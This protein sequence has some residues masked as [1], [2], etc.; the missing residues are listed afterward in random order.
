[1][2]LLC[3]SILIFA[4][5]ASRQAVSSPSLS[6]SQAAYS[7]R[8]EQYLR[9]QMGKYRIPGMAVAIVRDG[10][11]EYLEG[12]GVAGSDG[13]PVTPDTPFLLASVS[14]SVTAL[15][16]MQQVEQGHLALDDPVQKHL[17]WFE[18]AGGRGNQITVAHLLYHTSGFSELS[19][20]QANLATDSPQALE[21][22]VRGLKDEELEFLPGESYQYSN[23]NYAVL[24]LLIQQISGQPYEQYIKEQ[25]FTPLEMGHS[26]TSRAQAIAH[27]AASAHY[28]FFGFPVLVDNFVP[29]TRFTLPAGG[30]WSSASDM[31]RYLVAH[32]N[33]GS[34]GGA[35]LLSP[36]NVQVLHRPGYMFDDVQG[37]AMGW[38]SNRGFMPHDQLL[39]TGSSLVD[40][41]ELTVLFHEG[42]WLGY[43]SVAF[44]IPEL[45]YGLVLLM[46][47]NDPTIPSVFRF[48]A[49][50]VTL[51]STGGEA[52]YFPPAE[53]FVQRRS[54]A[55]FAVAVLLLAAGLVV[56]M[57]LIKQFR[58]SGSLSQPRRLRQLLFA[59]G[60]L[61]LTAA[62]L[63][64]LLL[65]LLPDNNANLATL[66]RFVP[67]VGMLL[68]VLL[69]LAAML[70]ATCLAMI[71]SLS[72]HR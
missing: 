45:D 49:W 50:D 22:G 64:Y 25:V 11:V 54:R 72:S 3:A 6:A 57:R 8:L 10:E 47:S 24:G 19:G 69:I 58:N 27:G 62:L 46:N 30:L 17:P 34:I 13:G 65:V 20:L 37:Y 33:G 14:K 36:A 53:G 16:V 55:L 68:L 67:D 31:S 23:L 26:Y 28:P 60:C 1:M 29:Y 35:S 32:L 7:S 71:Y 44:L 59:A 38:T 51:I 18:V 15:G 61:V 48:F 52:Q 42:D 56:S 2:P 70:M 43:K 41:G 5:A 21:A 63:S 4:M 39:D 40:R 12:L 66:L 9:A